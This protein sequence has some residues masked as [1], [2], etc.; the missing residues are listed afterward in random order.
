M[1]LHLNPS[2][3]RYTVQM[4]LIFRYVCQISGTQTDTTLKIKASWDAV[5]SLRATLPRAH[6]EKCTFYIYFIFYLYVNLFLPMLSKWNVFWDIESPKILHLHQYDY[7]QWLL[8]GILSVSA[9]TNFDHP[10]VTCYCYY[11]TLR[12]E[13]Y[14]TNSLCIDIGRKPVHNNALSFLISKHIEQESCAGH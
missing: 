14:S 10:S 11:E 9:E 5:Y 7:W 1:V 8:V 2:W 3:K 13:P 4:K 6:L 12:V